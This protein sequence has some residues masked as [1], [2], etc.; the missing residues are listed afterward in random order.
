MSEDAGVLSCGELVSMAPQD[1][2]LTRAARLRSLYGSFECP[3]FGRSHSPI[4]FENPHSLTL[5]VPFQAG[6]ARRTWADEGAFF[7]KPNGRSS[8]PNPLEKQTITSSIPCWVANAPRSVGRIGLGS[9]FS[10]PCVCNRSRVGD[11]RIGVPWR[12]SSC[13]GRAIVHALEIRKRRTSKLWSRSIFDFL[14]LNGEALPM[15]DQASPGSIK[16]YFI[17]DSKSICLIY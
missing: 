10:S 3:I 2:L 15:R 1:R 6:S 11:P 4:T 8:R 17:Q 9:R 12:F 13:V 5:V 7:T 14:E 16:E